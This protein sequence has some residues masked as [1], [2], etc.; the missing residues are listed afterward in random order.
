MQDL[1]FCKVLVGKGSQR[2]IG[3]KSEGKK[4]SEKP[5]HMGPT[6]QNYHQKLAISFFFPSS[7]D[8]SYHHNKWNWL[9]KKEIRATNPM[10]PK[11]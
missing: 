6:N 3:S 9:G 5:S 1:H 2:S 7:L 10:L 8:Q 4:M 11:N